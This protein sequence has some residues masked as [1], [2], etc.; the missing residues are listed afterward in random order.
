M[1]L[2]ENKGPVTG[3]VS[4]LC[5]VLLPRNQPNNVVETRIELEL[6]EHV[7]FI[8]VR[9]RSKSV[10]AFNNILIYNKAFGVDVYYFN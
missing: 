5:F 2:A 1:L 9:N 3:P 4:V 10:P 6:N 8:V 7:A